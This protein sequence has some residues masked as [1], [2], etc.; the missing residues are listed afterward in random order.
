MPKYFKQCSDLSDPCGGRWCEFCTI[1]TDTESK[2]CRFRKLDIPNIAKEILELYESGESIQNIRNITK[3]GRETTNW[4]IKTAIDRGLVTKHTK[5]R[6][7]KE[8]LTKARELKLKGY[9][10]AEVARRVGCV[11]STVKDWITKG[12]I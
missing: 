3:E 5:C 4:I 11:K 12:Y 1:L 2:G 7:P 6:T 8:I 9:N 10:N